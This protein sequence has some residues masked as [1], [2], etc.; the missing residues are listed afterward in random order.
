[1]ADLENVLHTFLWR[2][3]FIGFEISLVKSLCMKPGLKL[4]VLF[5]AVLFSTV[6]VHAQPPVT[7][8]EYK[9]GVRDYLPRIGCAADFSYLKGKSLTE[10]FLARWHR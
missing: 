3:L 8:C 2:G 9:K 5:I 6:S 10:K 7:D 4:S 1:M